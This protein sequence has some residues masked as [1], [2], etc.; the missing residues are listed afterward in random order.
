MG[1]HCLVDAKLTVKVGFSRMEVVVASSMVVAD[2]SAP[3]ASS[4]R[5]LPSNNAEEYRA[6]VTASLRRILDSTF[7]AA[8]STQERRKRS[9]EMGNE[10]VW[11]MCKEVRER[12]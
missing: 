7:R 1:W 9:G 8:P 6:V 4:A 10:C 5:T 2:E 3:S 12:R 11:R